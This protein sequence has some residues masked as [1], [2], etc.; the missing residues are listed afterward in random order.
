MPDSRTV[1]PTPDCWMTCSPMSPLLSVE[2]QVH[3]L[4]NV[5]KLSERLPTSIEPER[6][7]RWF[8]V[9]G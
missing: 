7:R 6:H 5:S 3:A 9:R 2:K 8:L 4:W 1:L